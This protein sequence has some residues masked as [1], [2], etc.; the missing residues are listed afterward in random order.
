MPRRRYGYCVECGEPIA[1]GRLE[2]DHP[3][4]VYRMCQRFGI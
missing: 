1:I 4:T 2:F 3:P